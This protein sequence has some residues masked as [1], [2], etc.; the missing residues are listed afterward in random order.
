MPYII[1]ISW[2][3]KAEQ[4]FK[5]P[6]FDQNMIPWLE[7]CVETYDKIEQHLGAFFLIYLTL[8]LLLWIFSLF[9]AL[10]YTV[11]NKSMA[12]GSPEMI[13]H[14]VGKYL[15]GKANHVPKVKRVFQRWRIGISC[16]SHLF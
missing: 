1:V 14:S 2:L 15:N 4:K 11:G 13:L 3:K 5:A 8:D 6:A 9:L 7:S 12:I 16:I 10:A